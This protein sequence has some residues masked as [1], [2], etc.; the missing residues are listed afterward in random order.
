M[1]VSEGV[2]YPEKPSVAELSAVVFATVVVLVSELPDGDDIRETVELES[3]APGTVKEG[4]V[5]DVMSAA[6]LFL[7][8]ARVRV[9]RAGVRGEAGVGAAV[10]WAP[11]VPVGGKP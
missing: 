4:I 11:G 7:A 1:K 9:E 5:E 3:D 2:P 6:A 10:S 8:D